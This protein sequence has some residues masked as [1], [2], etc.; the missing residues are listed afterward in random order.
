RH[1]GLADNDRWMASFG[2]GYQIDKHTSV[3]LAYSYLWI[4]P[5][6]AN[7]H[8]PCTGTY[9]E[10]DDNSVGGA[11]E[12]TANGGTFRASYY[13]SHAHIFGLQLNKRL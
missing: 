13:D 1:P 6:D 3:D 2:L 7:F 11:S 10:R 8:E 5:G 12:C 9:Y 4:A